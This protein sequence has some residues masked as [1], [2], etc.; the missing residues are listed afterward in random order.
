MEIDQL[1]SCIALVPQEP[2]L[3]PG[4]IEYNIGLGAGAGHTVTMRQIEDC[5]KAVGLHDFISSLPDGYNTECG[6]SSGS[7]LSGGQ[8]QRLSLA[9]ALIRDPSILLLDEPTSA[10]DAHSERQVQDALTAASQGRTTILVA[11]RLAS[12]Q[13]VDK[14]IVFDRGTVV[15]QGTHHELVQKEGLYASMAKAQALS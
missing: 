4:T 9:R 2:E 1:R 13:H 14:I 11:H 5:A 3:F 6:S 12:I 8:R 15:E 7:Q 10:L